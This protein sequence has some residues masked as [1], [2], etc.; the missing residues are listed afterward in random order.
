MEDIIWKSQDESLT[1]TKERIVYNT[2]TAYATVAIEQV[3][4]LKIEKQD[5]SKFGYIGFGVT[6][7]GLV[8]LTLNLSPIM[9]FSTIGLGVVLFFASFFMSKTMICIGASEGGIVVPLGKEDRATLEKAFS[10]LEAAQRA[11]RLSL[12]PKINI[13]IEEIKKVLSS[14]MQNNSGY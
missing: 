12:I 1:F 3:S 5:N 10:D 6:L 7:I 13:D 8:L 11:M 4:C 9:V 14:D 2:K